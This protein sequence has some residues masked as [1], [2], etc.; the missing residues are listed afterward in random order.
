M[1]KLMDTVQM[2][3]TSDEWHFEQVEGKDII[4]CAVKGDNVSFK[5]HFR[6]NEDAERLT[7]YCVSPN[8]VPEDK[9]GIV[10]EYITR[11]NYGLSLGNLEMDMND[12]EVRSKAAVDVEGGELTPTMAG[13]VRN[14]AVNLMDQYYPGLMAILFSGQTAAAA[15]KQVEKE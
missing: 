1:G 15:I 4:R 3:L 12:G 10:A 5:L 13:S 6:A 14:C 7:V 2:L 9:R 8:A 11:A